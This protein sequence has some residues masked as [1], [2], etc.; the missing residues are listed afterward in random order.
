MWVEEPSGV[1]GDRN[2]IPDGPWRSPL[3][4]VVI[5]AFGELLWCG[6]GDLRSARESSVVTIGS[7]ASTTVAAVAGKEA[8]SLS[9][10][11][12]PCAVDPTIWALDASSATPCRWLSALYRRS[13]RL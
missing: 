12:R 8:P 6:E 10:L 13:L 4:V 7:A 1:G 2:G 11:R 5:G 3:P 9:D